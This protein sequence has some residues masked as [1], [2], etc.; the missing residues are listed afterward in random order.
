MSGRV[1]AHIE[2]LVNP[3]THLRIGEVIQPLVTMAV[4]GGATAL[5]P[6]PNTPEGL[7]TPDD[8][9]AYVQHAK[10]AELGHR[11]DFIPIALLNEDTAPEDIDRLAD[12]GIF[13]VKIYPLNRT[14]KSHTGV[15]HYTRLL[16]AVRR[17]GERGVR[18]HMHPEYPWMT[19]V[20]RDAEYAFL[21]VADIL[22]TETDATLVWEHGTDARC[23]PFWKEMA[24]TGRFYVTLTAHHL[25][26]DEDA[27]F[28]D[29]R[30]ACKPPIK[31]VR[32][33]ME[34]RRLVR[35]DH[36]WVMAGLDDAPHNEDAKH[37]DHGRCACGAYTGRF[38]LQLYAHALLGKPTD[39]EWFVNF[40]SRNARVLYDLSP[41]VPGSHRLVFQPFTIPY[42]YQIGPWSVQPFWAGET[43]DWSLEIA[44]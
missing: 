44:A 31:T 11:V 2:G 1:V 28:G 8:V 27:T 14:T 6:M 43:I 35:E 20:N 3:H 33:C 10:Q 18:V 37:V 41:G 23:I 7:R 19:F 16:S 21:P 26:T 36:P 38:G 12:A 39:I 13:D 42:R 4:K 22:L 40:T 30:A 29:V 9:S 24:E 25:A 15:R 17:C 32:D 5:G 34:L